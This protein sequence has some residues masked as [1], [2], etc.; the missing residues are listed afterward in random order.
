M[1][2]PTHYS[3]AVSGIWKCN[4]SHIFSVPRRR[5]STWA[6]N[7]CTKLLTGFEPLLVTLVFLVNFGGVH[8]QISRPSTPDI[9]FLRP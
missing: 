2:S 3:E 7:R 1:C 6:T 4:F 5:G 8:G 9:V